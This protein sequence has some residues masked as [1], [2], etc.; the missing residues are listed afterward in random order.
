MQA[1]QEHDVILASDGE[2][3]SYLPLSGL[4]YDGCVWNPATGDVGF[5]ELTEGLKASG[6]AVDDIIENG[7]PVVI[8][9]PVG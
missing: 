6:Y 4:A 3:N 8:L 7:E 1:N 5:K 9:W 2:G